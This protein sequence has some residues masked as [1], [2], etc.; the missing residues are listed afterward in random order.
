MKSTDTG[1]TADVTLEE[2]IVQSIKK[3]NAVWQVAATYRGGEVDS[4]ALEKWSLLGY[5]WLLELWRQGSGG[6][7][8][9]FDSLSLF[10]PHLC[11]IFFFWTLTDDKTTQQW[12]I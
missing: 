4:A 1:K 10:M 6:L 9:L 2:L 5:W 8:W 12:S 11:I 7:E 3:T